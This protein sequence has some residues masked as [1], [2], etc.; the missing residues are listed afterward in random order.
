MVTRYGEYLRRRWPVRPVAADTPVDRGES[1]D[2]RWGS[3]SPAEREVAVLA[4][5]GWPNSAI[6]ERRG[7]SVRT[8]DAQVAGVRQK[9]LIGSRRRIPDHIPLHL[10]GVVAAERDTAAGRSRYRRRTPRL[11]GR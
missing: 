6:A 3:L 4:A 8:V 7:S 9:L 11:P 10:A 1:A 5:A 2:S